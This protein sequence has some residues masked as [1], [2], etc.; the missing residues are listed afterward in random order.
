MKL[1][2][3]YPLVRLTFRI[4]SLF[5]R[6]E[7][8]GRENMPDGVPLVICANHI[9]SFDPPLLGLHLPRY[10]VY[11]L[12]KKELFK[13]RVFGTILKGSGA[14]PLNR[15]G[16]SGA[17]F[18]TAARVIKHKGAIIIFPEGKRNPAGTLTP[19]M[20]GAGYLAAAFRTRVVPVAITGTETIRG[21]WWF[22]KRHRVKITIGRPFVIT[23]DGKKPDRDDLTAYGDRIMRA[24]AELLPEDY[25]GVYGKTES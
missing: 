25:R 4:M 22:L 16:A 2:W 10:G 8:T 6:V 3:Y 23:G 18:K 21:K 5:T 11:F 12:A 14:I 9:S 24:I 19:A 13:N 17:S 1:A 7:V 20:P 15:D